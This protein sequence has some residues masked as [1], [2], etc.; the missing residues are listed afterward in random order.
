MKKQKI[1]ET[2]ILEIRRKR[3]RIIIIPFGYLLLKKKILKLVVININFVLVESCVEIKDL[4][5]V[6]M[7]IPSSFSVQ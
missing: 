1:K 3:R 7:S 4:A 2:E 5:F 6:L